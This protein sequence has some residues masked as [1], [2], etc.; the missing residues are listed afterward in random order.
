[1]NLH[2]SLEKLKNSVTTSPYKRCNRNS[3]SSDL[4]QCE[5]YF[6]SFLFKSSYFFIFKEKRGVGSI[7]VLVNIRNSKMATK[8][9]RRT[10]PPP[11]QSSPRLAC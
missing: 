6:L 7:F 1:M 11:V 10:Y 4:L 9:R 8:A 2:I 3:Y 5:S